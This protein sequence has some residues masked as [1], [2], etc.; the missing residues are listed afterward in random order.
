VKRYLPL[1]AVCAVAVVAAGCGAVN[2]MANGLTTGAR[3]NGES[4]FKS[5]C[6]ACHTLAAAGTT[7]SNSN[8][9]GPNL[10]YAFGPDR[11]QGF[12]DST[13]R[14]IVLGQIYYA[15]P[16]P[17]TDWPPGSANAVTGMPANLLTG[18]SAQDVA[19]YVASVA[20]TTHGPGQYFDCNTGAY[21]G[22]ASGT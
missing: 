12:S 5:T 2:H 19:A 3:G 4:L 7:G 17:E 20:G 15:D 6:G 22:A 1:L 16:D 18:Q 11:C 21:A 9:L 10:D 14:D 13:I 8:T